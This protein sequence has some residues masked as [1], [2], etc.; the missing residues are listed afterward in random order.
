MPCTYT[1]PDGGQRIGFRSADG[2]HRL[3]DEGVSAGHGLPLT[4]ID[5][6]AC[7]VRA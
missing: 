7:A 6:P 3:T 2:D 5:K 1:A 4:V